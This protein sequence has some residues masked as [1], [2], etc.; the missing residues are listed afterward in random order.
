[1]AISAPSAPALTDLELMAHLY[2]RAGFGATPD[3]LQRA[4]AQGYEATVEEI[5]NTEAQPPLDDYLIHRYY[6]DVQ[7]GRQINSSQYGWVYR[8][9]NTRR[10]LE[11]KMTLFWHG[12]F[13]TAYFKA[14][15]G[16]TM[17]NQIHMLRKHCLGDLRTLLIELSKDPAM[18]HWLDN[19][20]NTNEVHNE[21]YGRELLELFSMG[22]GN[23]TEDDVKNCARAFTGWGLKRTI[24]G[25]YPYS[26]FDLEFEFYPDKHDDGEKVLLGERGNF[27]GPDAIDVILRQPA[28]ATFIAKRLYQFFVSDTP[29]PD[30]IAELAAALRA[31]GYDIRSAMRTLFLSDY[32]RS[33][34]VFCARVKYPVELVVGVVRLAGDFT[35]PEYD[36]TPLALACR[37]MG[38]DLMNPP[39]VEGWHTGKEWID[40]GNL[41][42]RINFASGHIGDANKPGVRRI[43]ER[44]REQGPLS[45]EELVD[46]CVEMVGPVAFKDGTY[47]SLVGF[48]AQDRVPRFD[49]SDDEA[50][51]RRIVRLLQLIVST[52]EYQM[53]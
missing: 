47:E 9:I 30:A 53:A 6:V 40:T 33:P 20:Y 24:P 19:Q 41:V 17:V 29:D 4:L 38:Q 32:F 5:V 18:I 14:E 46:Q 50:D 31:S 37:Y 13:A 48:I 1:M 36:I 44:L 45:P 35:Y 22:R 49:G 25:F 16:K 8:M 28:T 42:E 43:I 11:E 26:H 7:E 3:E 21:N 12:L 10:P 27:D 34:D 15:K 52:R 39:S 2:R 23:Y 51:E